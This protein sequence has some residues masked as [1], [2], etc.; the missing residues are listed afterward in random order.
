M[1]SNRGLLGPDELEPSHDDDIARRSAS[2]NIPPPVGNLTMGLTIL[3][4]PEQRRRREADHA[5]RE[6]TFTVLRVRHVN[7]S[8][9]A[10]T[11]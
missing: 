8:L 5:R 2:M 10:R 1:S 6:A 9:T 3:T 11:A 7:M 4:V